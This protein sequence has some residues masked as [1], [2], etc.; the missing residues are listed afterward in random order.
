MTQERL[1]LLVIENGL[2]VEQA[3]LSVTVSEPTAYLERR[4]G[5]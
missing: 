1:G 2:S 3:L 5:L 4:Q